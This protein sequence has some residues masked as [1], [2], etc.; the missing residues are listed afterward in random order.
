MADNIT[1]DPGT[2]P[3][4]AVKTDE[5]TGGHVQFVKLLSGA[6]GSTEP[7]E[8]T[9]ANGLEVTVTAIAA[10]DNNI[11][12]VDVATM[13]SI[14]VGTA[15]PAGTANIG[16]VDVASIAAGTNVIGKV[17]VDQT[18]PGT[19]NKVSIGTDGTV[20][21][22]AEI[23]AGTKAIGKLI[24]NSGVDI[25]DV[26]INNVAT[27]PVLIQKT[28]GAAAIVPVTADLDTGG[29][30]QTSEIQALAGAA[31]GGAVPIHA[32]GGVEAN[33]L[34]VTIASDST[35]VVSID[36]NSGA[37]TVD[38]VH[39]DIRHLVAA[40]DVVTVVGQGGGT[41]DVKIS[42]DG[43][44]VEL[45]AGTA[46]IGTVALTAGTAEFGKLAAGTAEI[47]SVKIAANGKTRVSKRVA[48]AAGGTTGGTIWDPSAAKFCLTKI[49]VSCSV[50]GTIQLFDATDS[51]NTVIG[52]ILSLTA[53]GGW[54]ESWPIDMPYL[55]ATATNILKYTS[56]AAFAGSVYV[57]GWAV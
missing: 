18:T 13:P 17:T 38:A 45:K 33:A 36:D 1:I 7:I 52:P 51:G 10:G 32:G 37:I 31:S 28:T 20:A 25:G 48:V 44:A 6:D 16:D 29:G 53:G 26:T 3:S 42:L 35:G 15:L 55:S 24:T 43:E 5:I 9:A 39:L 21:L 54:S 23:P 11:G 56:S 22:N 47:G 49:I 34:R 12:N 50:A 30:T 57:E 19:T 40:D 41:S 4:I 14:T 8:G 2:S 46:A 27:E